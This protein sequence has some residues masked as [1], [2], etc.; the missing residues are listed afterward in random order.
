MSSM[1]CIFVI[2]IVT[3]FGS[4]GGFLVKI[5]SV[6]GLCLPFIFHLLKKLLL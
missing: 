1:L 6:P 3:H 5:A 2:L 4:E